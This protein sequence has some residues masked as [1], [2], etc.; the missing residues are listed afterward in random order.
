MQEKDVIELNEQ[1]LNIDFGE[2]DVIEEKKKSYR[3]PSYKILISDD[4]E[5]IHKMTKL[6]L[7]GFQM[8]GA[9]LEFLDAYSAKETIKVL[10]NHRDVAIILLD[11]VMEEDDSGLKV[12]KYMREV[13]KNNITRIILRTGQPGVAPEER[14]IVDYEIDD[15]KCKADLTIQKLISTMYVCLR[16]HKNIRALNRHKEG[17]HRVINASHDLFTYHSFSEFLNGML[18]QVI[19]LYDVNV[20]SF[21]VRDEKY[22]VDGMAFIKIMDSGK[23]LAGTGKYE[24]MIGEP[25]NLEKCPPDLCKLITYFE[26]IDESELVIRE[27]DFLGI[28]KQNSDRMVKNYIILETEAN[29]DNIDL[30]KLFLS[31]FSLAIDNF[32]LNMNVNETQNEIIY[33]ISEVVENRC[34]STANHLRRVS[35]IT[36]LLS[37]KIGFDKELADLISRASVMHDVGKIGISDAILLKPGKLN[38]D[39]FEYIKTHTVIGYNIFKDS[40]LPL[41]HMAAKIALYHHERYDGKGYPEGLRGGEIPKECEIVAVADVFDALLSKRPYKDKWPLEE[42]TRYIMEERGKQ[43]APDVVDI[44]FENIK[45]IQDIIQEFLD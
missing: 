45:E 7:K 34:D 36:K 4:D 22:T 15:Y 40:Q 10:Q 42:V 23:V 38:A 21:Y 18:Q 29:N 25:L 30:I 6:V 33:R 8:E 9:S 43:F 16:A 35:N 32:T 41:L 12:V 1:N 19:A 31:N 13:M 14:I 20:D 26:T 24:D 17:L 37:E 27:G 44:L 2:S 11:V 3:N 5:E 28:Y 39:E